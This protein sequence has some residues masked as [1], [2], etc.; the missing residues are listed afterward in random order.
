MGSV[1]VKGTYIRRGLHLA[2]GSGSFEGFSPI[3]LNGILSVFL[4]QKST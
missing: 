2:R 1:V 4:K 3:G